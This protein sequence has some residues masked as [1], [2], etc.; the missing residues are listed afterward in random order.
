MG[1]KA[2]PLDFLDARRLIPILKHFTLFKCT[3]AWDEDAV[4]PAAPISMNRPEEFVVRT[5]SSQ[6]FL[7]L[8]MHLAI[9]DR[10]RKRHAVCTLAR[11]GCGSWTTPPRLYAALTRGEL[12]NIRI[13][14]GPTRGRF[15]AWTDEYHDVVA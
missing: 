14:G 3:A 5:E 1:G 13:S 4:F 10:A 9:P 8:E 15:L 11:P 6:H 2:P 7:M 12:R